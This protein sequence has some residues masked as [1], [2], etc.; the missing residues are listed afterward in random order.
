VHDRPDQ[1]DKE[2]VTL[3]HKREKTKIKQGCWNSA[4]QQRL[5]EANG[6]PMY[7]IGP[8]PLSHNCTIA[9]VTSSGS[10]HAQLKGALQCDHGGIQKRWEGQVHI[11]NVMLFSVLEDCTLYC[12]TFEWDAELFTQFYTHGWCRYCYLL[13][14]FSPES[15][16]E[17]CSSREKLA[18][19]SLLSWWDLLTE[20][21]YSWAHTHFT[22]L[23]AKNSISNKGLPSNHAISV[24]NAPNTIH[25]VWCCWNTFKFLLFFLS[26][27]YI[28]CIGI[29]QSLIFFNCC[30]NSYNSFFCNF[31]NPTGTAVAI[32]TIFL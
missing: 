15:L 9:V 22:L 16:S 2:I 27:S 11:Y 12:S 32:L 3:S 25:K 8:S 31:L 30:Y 26:L 17:K 19:P 21:W 5:C 10:N 6:I 28:I 13:Q 23:R 7:N 4:L 1:G 14:D 24:V 18:V 29:L 20:K